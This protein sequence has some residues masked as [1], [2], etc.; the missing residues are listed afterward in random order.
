LSP[1]ST[2][3]RDL[4]RSGVCG[5]DDLIMLKREI[6]EREIS[7]SLYKVV[8]M[9]FWAGASTSHFF[10]FRVLSEADSEIGS[11]A[12]DIVPVV[13]YGLGIRLIMWILEEERRTSSMS[14]WLD[15]V[16]CCFGAKDWRRPEIKILSREPL[17]FCKDFWELLTL[18][19]LE[20]SLSDRSSEIYN[21]SLLL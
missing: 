16:V 6:S 18:L 1:V 13:G 19:F 2:L 12:R 14:R 9:F 4:S 5:T 8:S 7:D 11:R 10:I 15:S 17:V 20:S 3:F 21:P